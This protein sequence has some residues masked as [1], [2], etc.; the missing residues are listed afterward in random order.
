MLFAAPV[1][2]NQEISRNGQG[3]QLAFGAL[4]HA[5]WRLMAAVGVP[6]VGMMEGA[7]MEMTLVKAQQMEMQHGVMHCPAHL[8]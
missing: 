5:V 7:M 3:S 8:D 2:T 6:A 1:C 4:S